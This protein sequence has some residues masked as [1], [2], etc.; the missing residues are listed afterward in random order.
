MTSSPI[1]LKHASDGIEIPPAKT[2]GGSGILVKRAI[3]S[4]VETGHDVVTQTIVT[5]RHVIKQKVHL[6]WTGGTIA[7]VL[8]SELCGPAFASTINA[9]LEMEMLPP[10]A[11]ELKELMLETLERVEVPN[12]RLKYRE[13]LFKIIEDIVLNDVTPE[14]MIDRL[15]IE[16]EVSV[17]GLTGQDFIE[18]LPQ[19]LHNKYQFI[20][21]DP[22]ADPDEEFSFGIDSTEMLPDSMERI[23]REIDLILQ[24]PASQNGHIIVT[25]GTDTMANDAAYQALRYAMGIDRPIVFTGSQI[26]TGDPLTDAYNNFALALKASELPCG[27]VVIAFGAKISRGPAASKLDSVDKDGFSSP[28]QADIAKITGTH[29]RI[30]D[31]NLLPRQLNILSN[32][33]VYPGLKGR[34]VVIKMDPMLASDHDYLRSSILN[35]DLH[36]AIIIEGYAAGNVPMSIAHIIKEVS[37]DMLV[38]F[39]PSG[40]THGEPETLYEGSPEISH[41][42]SLFAKGMVPAVANMKFQWLYNRALE[43]GYSEEDTPELLEFIRSRFPFNYVSEYPQI[44]T[45]NNTDYFKEITRLKHLLLHSREQI[46]V[47]TITLEKYSEIYD[48]VKMEW[49]NRQVALF[50]LPEDE[51]RKWIENR[52]ELDIPTETIFGLWKPEEHDENWKD[53]ASSDIAIRSSAHREFSRQIAVIDPRSSF[54]PINEKI[55]MHVF[56]EWKNFATN[57]INYIS[58][59]IENFYSTSGKQ[60]TTPLHALKSELKREII[61]NFLK[62]FLQQ[63]GKFLFSK[64]E[65]YILICTQLSSGNTELLTRLLDEGKEEQKE[66]TTRLPED[67]RELLCRSLTRITTEI[68][69]NL[70]VT[71]KGSI[72]SNISTTEK[73]AQ[74]MMGMSLDEFAERVR[75]FLLESEIGN[76]MRPSVETGESIIDLKKIRHDIADLA[77]Q[78]ELH[79]TAESILGDDALRHLAE[80][81]ADGKM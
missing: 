21:H 48:R 9:L 1:R 65:L 32:K 22:F 67:L 43:L 81:I 71:R 5:E 42:G 27:E 19:D 76:Q 29:L 14:E 11:L 49:L 50:N 62:E 75:T 63:K 66:D 70:I 8:R 18:R 35:P 45:T 20:I 38:I 34:S 60:D 4:G 79:V 54:A 68:I 39:A 2:G 28:H 33:Q 41:S 13:Q 77:N 57:M 7:S 25:H 72:P 16:F 64:K 58:E 10:T 12:G 26:R 73:Y 24:D 55:A 69:E 47:S 53:L 78:Y 40:A 80:E 59:K 31:K 17:P 74:Q 23:G 36:D 56:H 51:R 37:H 3:G 61:Q 46:D 6:I 15:K 52:K 30:E 44:T